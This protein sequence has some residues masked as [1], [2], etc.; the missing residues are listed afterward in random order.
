MI[1]K[2]LILTTLIYGLWT[3]DCGLISANPERIQDAQKMAE[4]IHKIASSDIIYAD[5]EL[6]ALYYQNIQMIDLLRQI[7]NLLEQ[8]VKR[9]EE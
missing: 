7:R 5:E 8:Q 6:K 3:V 4:E 2:I 1:R 9:E